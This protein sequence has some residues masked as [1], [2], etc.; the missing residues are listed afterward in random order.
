MKQNGQNK[1]MLKCIADFKLCFEMSNFMLLSK[2][3]VAQ[4]HEILDLVVA[5]FFVLYFRM[6]IALP[7]SCLYICLNPI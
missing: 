2:L 6:Q 3:T 1:R 4:W 5:A 7:F